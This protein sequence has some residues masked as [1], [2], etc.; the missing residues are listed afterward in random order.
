MTHEY[1]PFSWTGKGRMIPL[2]IICPKFWI[3]F[4]SSSIEIKSRDFFYSKKNG[5]QTEIQALYFIENLIKCLCLCLIFSCQILGGFFVLLKNFH[6]LSRADLTIP[7]M[8]FSMKLAP[9]T[10]VLPSHFLWVLRE[11]QHKVISLFCKKKLEKKNYLENCKKSS[12]YFCTNW[13][14]NQG[15]IIK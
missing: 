8:V 14:K 11:F 12:N 4:K 2:K 6:F 1:Y 5:L 15:Q 10:S 13:P 9:V 3:I 7:Y